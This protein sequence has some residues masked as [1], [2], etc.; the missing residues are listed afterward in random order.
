MKPQLA[1]KLGTFLMASVLSAGAQVTTFSVRTEEVRID[2]LVSKDGKPVEGLKADD[3]TVL[4]NDVPQ[5]LESASF[6]Q[7]PISATLVL[8]MSRSVAGKQLDDL[9]AAGSALIKGLKEDE[10]AALITFSHTIKLDSPLTMDLDRVEDALARIQP[11][12]FGKTSVI[13]A[14]YAGLVQAESSA[15]RPML[16][17]FSDG[18]DTSSWLTSEM[19]LEAA[20]FSDTVVYTVSVGRLPERKFLRDLSKITGGSPFEIGSTENLSEVFLSILEEFRHRY[21]LTYLPQDLSDF[22]WHK[23]EVRVKQRGVEV[24]HRPGY[25]PDTASR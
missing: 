2:V 14:S 16:I 17:V 13:D 8:D 24:K 15:D 7:I 11:Q 25:A 23:V 20:K 4:D 10:R 1:A 19:V 12:S 22:G 18:L 5:I 9:K 21:L 6:Q 3:F